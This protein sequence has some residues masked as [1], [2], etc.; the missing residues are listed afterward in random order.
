VIE[1][2][3]SAGAQPAHI[4]RGTCSPHG[5]TS[6]YSLSSI[7]DQKS[8]TLVDVS[9]DALKKTPHSISVQRSKKASASVA[10]GQISENAAP[11]PT[12]TA[13]GD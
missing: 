10:C 9:L 4:T 7:V 8:T 12:I 3:S 13:G 2:V 11:V 6:A 5:G 1:M